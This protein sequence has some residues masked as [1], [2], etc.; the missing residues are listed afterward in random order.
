M[1]LEK[2]NDL[3]FPI[4]SGSIY[5]YSWYPEEPISQYPMAIGNELALIAGLQV[6][7]K[8]CWNL[9]LNHF[10]VDPLVSAGVLDSVKTSGANFSLTFYS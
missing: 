3:L 9:S 2:G 8:H 1:Q 6:N 10:V 7:F 4:M 5:S